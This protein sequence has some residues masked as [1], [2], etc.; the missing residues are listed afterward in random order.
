[1]AAPSR[2]TPTSS[3]SSPTPPAPAP[4]DWPLPCSATLRANTAPLKKQVVRLALFASTYV[5][6]PCYPSTVL[7][8]PKRTVRRR[9]RRQLNM[10]ATMEAYASRIQSPPFQNQLHELE[11]AYLSTFNIFTTEVDVVEHLPS[12]TNNAYVLMKIAREHDVHVKAVTSECKIN[13]EYRASLLDNDTRET[14]KVVYVGNYNYFTNHKETKWSIL[15]QDKVY[16]DL[17]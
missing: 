13:G 8:F 9:R 7:S 16:F 17:E 12:R 3:S 4:S 1:M 11:D 15:P 14:A 5:I 2:A 10:E 6:I